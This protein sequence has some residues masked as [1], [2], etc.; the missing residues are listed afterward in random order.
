[1]YTFFG[2]NKSYILVRIE[3]KYDFLVQI[4]ENLLF[5][6]LIYSWSPCYNDVRIV[7]RWCNNF[8][9]EAKDTL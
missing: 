2:F 8:Y 3:R 7:G 5:I 6:L 4:M 1:M 9:I